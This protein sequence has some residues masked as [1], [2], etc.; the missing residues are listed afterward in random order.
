MEGEDEEQHEE[1]DGT[2]LV[3]LKLTSKMKWKERASSMR[4]QMELCWWN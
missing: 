3:E 1:A 2:V 4:K